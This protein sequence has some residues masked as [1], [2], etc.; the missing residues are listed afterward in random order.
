MT[1]NRNHGFEFVFGL[2]LI[3][4]ACVSDFQHKQTLKS[5]K[6]EK[7]FPS[8]QAMTDKESALKITDI[9]KSLFSK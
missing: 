6:M 9:S 5:M 4:A 7:L 8:V 1:E 2:I 3:I